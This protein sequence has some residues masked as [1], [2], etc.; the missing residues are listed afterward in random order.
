MAIDALRPGLGAL[1][2]LSHLLRLQM[3]PWRKYSRFFGVLAI[4]ELSADFSLGRNPERRT[5]DRSPEPGGNWYDLG[6]NIVLGQV[7]TST[8]SPC[9]LIPRR[10]RG[11]LSFWFLTQGGRVGRADPG[12]W[13]GV[14]IQG[15]GG[16]LARVWK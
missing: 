16:A 12:L 14:P 13:L 1:S 2:Q 5:I 9:P 4:A 11:F 8:L 7:D 10:E 6:A 15:T 3:S